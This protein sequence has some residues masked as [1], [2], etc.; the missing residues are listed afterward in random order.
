MQIPSISN[1]FFI[2]QDECATDDEQTINPSDNLQ[3]T[4]Q[5]PQRFKATS[6]SLQSRCTILNF[7]D[8]LSLATFTPNK[9]RTRPF[10]PNSGGA[11]IY[12]DTLY[13]NE[14]LRI[15]MRE[16]RK[17]ETGNG[18]RNMKE[19]VRYL[20]FVLLGEDGGRKGKERLEAVV[21]TKSWSGRPDWRDTIRCLK[22]RV[23][24][25]G[26]DAEEA[27]RRS[28]EDGWVEVEVEVGGRWGLKGW[29]WEGEDW[30][31]ICQSVVC[32]GGW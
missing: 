8:Q 14:R 32:R 22:E 21:K 31:E 3:I 18:F 29:E 7:L 1:R 25:F 19:S 28:G 27:R 13:R 17:F 16:E 10:L 30:C 11:Q 2:L 23:E 15:C 4:I 5:H 20:A 12:H 9:L 6:P 26:E 24:D